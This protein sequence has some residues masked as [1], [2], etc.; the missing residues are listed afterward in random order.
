MSKESE[1]KQIIRNIAAFNS[2]LTLFEA[3]VTEREDTE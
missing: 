3:I 2:G 1:I